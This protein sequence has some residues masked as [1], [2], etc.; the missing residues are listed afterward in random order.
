MNF[1]PWTEVGGTLLV[2]GVLGLGIDY[3]LGK[4]REARD[5]ARLKRV[6][7]ETSPNMR[8]AVI[9]GF[10]F[11]NDDLV[12][13]ANP[14][15]LDDII[16]NSLSIRLGDATFADEVYRDIRDQA[17]RAPERRHDARVEIRLSPLSGI[18]DRSTAGAPVESATGSPLCD[19]TVRWEYSVVPKH[20][21]HRFAVTSDRAEYGEI[22]RDDNGTSAWY[23]TPKPSL[24]AASWTAFELVQYSVNGEDRPIR[25]ATRK[26]GQIYTVP[27]RLDESEAEEPVIVAFTYRT[28]T[29]QRGNLL[30]IGI[31]QPTHGIDIELD[32]SD[33]GIERVSVLGFIA[34]S[35]ATRIERTPDS[36]TGQSVRVGFDGWALPRSGWVLC[37]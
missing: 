8:D 28:V 26:N 32:Y 24:D 17:I 22:S 25:R 37:G 16:R 33:C 27:L 3:A 12:R 15:M 36:V 20:P 29:E 2:A 11:G 19:V 9:Q 7:A 21:V 35:Q 31:D 1:F 18:P 30:Y 23:L 13:V 10:A 5:T 6:L 34:S 14:E 4:D